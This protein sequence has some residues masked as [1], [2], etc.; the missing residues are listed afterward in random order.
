MAPPPSDGLAQPKNAMRKP[1]GALEGFR[2]KTPVTRDRWDALDEQARHRAF[3]VAG[4]TQLDIVQQAWTAIDKAIAA[5]TTIADF[6]KDIG[7]A[8]MKAWSGS[9]ANPSARLDTIFRTNVQSAYQAGKTELLSDPAVQAARPFKLFDAVLDT[10]T[11]DICEPLDGTLLPSDDPF[12]RT[13]T[14]LLHF[15]CRSNVITLR[16]S[17]AREMGISTRI[18]KHDPPLPGFGAPP[19]LTEWKPKATDYAAPL[20]GAPM[21]GAPPP[22]SEPPSPPNVGGGDGGGD[23]RRKPPPWNPPGIKRD[24]GSLAYEVS[25]PKRRLLDKT[26]EQPLADLLVDVRGTGITE[27]RAKGAIDS[28]EADHPGRIDHVR[29]VGDGYDKDYPD[30]DRR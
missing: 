26:K 11:S 15:N 25:G 28:L 2:S 3:T 16:P 1:V 7:P 22:P 13:H 18:P 8:L 21:F 14:P 19:S 20:R 29:I 6:K 9:V 12:W 24:G 4:T 17:Q 30:L 10:R 5:G 23:G 27:K